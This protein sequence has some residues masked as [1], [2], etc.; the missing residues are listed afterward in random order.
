MRVSPDSFAFS[1]PFKAFISLLDKYEIGGPLT[2]HLITEVLK[3][4]RDAIAEKALGDSKEVSALPD[5][6][7]K[8]LTWLEDSQHRK[9]PL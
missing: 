2:D 1:R 9:Q 7:K 8:S 4:L 3:I 5:L 6:D